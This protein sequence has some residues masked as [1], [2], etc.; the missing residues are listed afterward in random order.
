VM[1]MMMMI[2]MMTVIE[3]TSSMPAPSCTL[4]CSAHGR[5]SAIT[6]LLQIESSL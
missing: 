4:L 2:I 6:P 1:M 3:G 5:G